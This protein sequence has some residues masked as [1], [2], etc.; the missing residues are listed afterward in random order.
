MNCNHY[1]DRSER[2]RIDA[3]LTIFV[4]FYD[5]SDPKQYVLTLELYWNVITQL[6]LALRA[7][8]PWLVTIYLPITFIMLPV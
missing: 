8:L 3:E 5:A 4:D 6:L 2:V 7:L 1:F